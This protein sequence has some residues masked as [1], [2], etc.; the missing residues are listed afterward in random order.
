MGVFD[1]ISNIVFLLMGLFGISI[2]LK[3][4]NY[5]LLL[6]SIGMIVIILT[7]YPHK[8]KHSK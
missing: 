6:G 7:Q 8:E 1:A 5:W 4:V 2:Q 3:Q